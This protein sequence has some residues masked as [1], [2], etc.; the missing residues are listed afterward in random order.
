MKTFV[1]I[2]CAIAFAICGLG[3]GLSTKSPPP[4]IVIGN[5]LSMNAATPMKPFL[6]PQLSPA[7]DS[8]KTVTAP[9]TI[10]IRDTVTVYVKSSSTKAKLRKAKGTTATKKKV[11]VASSVSHQAPIQV[12]DTV[13]LKQPV[14]YLAKQVGMKEGPL[15]DSL[16][17]YEVHRVDSIGSHEY[18]SPGE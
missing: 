16:T 5:G 6:P 2:V 4:P 15:E 14:I 8:T 18:N 17:I 3:L 11:P 7:M 12:H 1:T 10:T 9:D 13:Y